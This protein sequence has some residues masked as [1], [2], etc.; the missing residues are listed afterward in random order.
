MMHDLDCSSYM[1][2]ECKAFME[3]KI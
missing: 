2:V 1:H 3:I